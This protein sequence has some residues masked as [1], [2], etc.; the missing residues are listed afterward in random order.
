MNS[1]A[2]VAN[3]FTSFLKLGLTSFG[4]PI[5]H[6]GYFHKELIEKQ[7][8]INEHQFSQLLAICQ[9]LPGPA[10]SQ[11]GFALGL[12]RAGWLGAFAAFI[13]FTLPSALL[14]IGFAS[15]LPLLSNPIGSAMTHGLKLVAVAV[16]ADAVFNMSN[17]LC[18]DYARR[19]IA[20]L[21]T[22]IL[23]T[24]GS[25]WSQILV[26]ILGA[27]AGTF[28]YRSNTTS[29]TTL[30]DFRLINYG[31]PFALLLLGLFLAILLASLFIP[32][33]SGL[34][35]IGQAFYRAGALVFGG[36]HIVLP[37][38]EEAVVNTGWMSNER[39]LAG[40]GASQAIPGPLFAFSAYLGAI[41]PS[42][43]AISWT[44]ALVALVF[45][46]LPGFLL[47]T[48]TLPLWQSLAS[49]PI[50]TNAIAG[51]NAVVVGILA[52]TLIDPIFT[53]SVLS[54]VDLFIASVAIIMLSRWH[55]SPLLVVLWSV[56]A[57]VLLTS[58]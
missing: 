58:L 20:L 49:K 54:I 52:A 48:A 28:L 15:A 34:V 29:D 5:A 27:I 44:G 2:N 46:F 7:Q 51:I 36:G 11:L 39:F 37:L 56:I 43:N 8:W 40:Y 10:S 1:T 13:A 14:L 21:A 16:V 6:I 41:I 26:I 33:Q 55:L 45:I 30:T 17:K 24:I 35:A 23:L 38:L 19:M 57:N 47:I 3:V 12:I 4:G 42:G 22:A 31:K 50:A 32:N 25:A 9:F 18:S 53:S